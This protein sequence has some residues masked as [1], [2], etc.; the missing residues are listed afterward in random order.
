LLNTGKSSAAF[1]VVIRA[2]A[3]DWRVSVIQFVKSDEWRVGDAF[4]ALS[5]RISVT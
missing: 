5:L 4:Q 2:A 1:G 3:H